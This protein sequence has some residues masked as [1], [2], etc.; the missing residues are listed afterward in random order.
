MP[1][2]LL[3]REQPRGPQALLPG[4]RGHWG[5]RHPAQPFVQDFLLERT[6]SY[7]SLLQIYLNPVNI[8]QIP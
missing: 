5:D 7:L 3:E 4:L 1:L 6:V 8:F 2:A